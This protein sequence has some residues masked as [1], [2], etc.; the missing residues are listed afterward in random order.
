MKPE[1]KETFYPN[2]NVE[3]Q[4]WYLNGKWHNEE[5]P[6]HIRYYENGQIRFRR[7]CLNGEFH[8]EEGP[9]CIRHYEDGKVEYQGWYLND[10]RIFKKDFT[11]LDMIK[12]MNAFELFSPLEIA[13]MKI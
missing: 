5:G 12:R 4:G 3:F 10:K 11:S 9:A 13:R 2:G 8:N 1:L 7:W 6:A